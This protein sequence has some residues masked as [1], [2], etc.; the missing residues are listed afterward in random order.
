[1][2]DH[3]ASAFTSLPDSRTVGAWR[4]NQARQALYFRQ[5]GQQMPAWAAWPC[6]QRAL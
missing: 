4:G 6:Q 1:M 5:D 2:R 3:T